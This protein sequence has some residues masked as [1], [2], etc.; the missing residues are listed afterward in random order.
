MEKT[1]RLLRFVTNMSEVVLGFDN[2]KSAHPH[3]R[4]PAKY[5]IQT[6]TH[7]ISAIASSDKFAY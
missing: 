1:T 7:L 4:R 5:N 3:F 6:A 2:S